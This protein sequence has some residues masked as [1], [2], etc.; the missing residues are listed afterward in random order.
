MGPQ[1]SWG[2]RRWITALLLCAAS[3]AHAAHRTP[4]VRRSA[5]VRR[6]ACV[7]LGE[8]TVRLGKPLGIVFEEAEVGKPMGVRVADL[9]AGGTA[10]LN[11][12][13]CVGDELVSTSAIIFRDR[14]VG[15][16]YTKFERQMVTVTKMEF[17]GVMSAIGSNDG[18]FGCIDVVLKLR[19]TDKTIARPIPAPGLAAKDEGVTWTA[20][21]GVKK[22]QSSMPIRPPRDAF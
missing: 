21:E 10:D 5:R 8:Y 12:R 4:H 3:G 6:A 2:A 16:G 9:V 18:R 22:G 7:A 15:G 1:D 13:V 14:G 20:L 19:P 17:D 11:G